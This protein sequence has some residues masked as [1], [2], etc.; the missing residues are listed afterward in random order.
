MLILYAVITLCS[1]IKKKYN[2]ATYELIL[3]CSF[4]FPF[5]WVFACLHPCLL[6]PCLQSLHMSTLTWCAICNANVLNE[7]GFSSWLCASTPDM[8]GQ[9]HCIQG[10]CTVP[11][12]WNW[13]IQHRGVQS[14][15]YYFQLHSC[16]SS[17]RWGFRVFSPH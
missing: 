13:W 3:Y 17:W 11:G 2:V 14:Q 1:D 5:T 8:Q 12:V 9:M 6:F 10:V 15:L 4:F 7:I 16:T